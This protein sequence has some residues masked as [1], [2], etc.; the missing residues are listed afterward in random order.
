MDRNMKVALGLFAVAVGL[1]GFSMVMSFRA[2]NHSS[3]PKVVAA[4]DYSFPGELTYSEKLERVNNGVYTTEIVGFA[5]TGYE[6]VI[7]SGQF[8]ATSDGLLFI[9][10]LMEGYAKDPGKVECFR[11]LPREKELNTFLEGLP[12]DFVMSPDQQDLLKRFQRAFD[13]AKNR[14][15]NSG[16]FCSPAGDDRYKVST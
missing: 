4:G 13:A 6:D 14:D 9:T 1:I 2:Q 7:A 11:A 12:K 16:V 10:Y 5:T 3:G 8:F 15:A